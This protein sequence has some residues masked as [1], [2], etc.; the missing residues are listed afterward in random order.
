MNKSYIEIHKE[1]LEPGMKLA[2]DIETKFGAT[3]L[4]KNSI[5][6]ADE[7][8]KLYNLDQKYFKIVNQNQSEQ[9]DNLYKIMNVKVEYQ[10]KI[11]Q[12]KELF[13]CLKNNDTLDKKEV[14]KL[15][16]E[17]IGLANNM[18][19][20]DVL[21][22]VRDTD[23]Y[24][25][26]HLLNVG[27]HANFFAEWLDLSEKEKGELTTAGIL[28]DIGKMKIPNEIL[29]KPGELNDEEYEIIKTHSRES[30]NIVKKADFISEKTRAGILTHH[31]QYNGKGYPL[32]LKGKEI[33]Y[34][35]RIL[36]IIDAFDAITSDKIYNPASSP[37][38][39]MRIFKEDK[40]QF[41]DYELKE[42]F[43]L[44]MPNIFVQEKV[45][46]NDGRVAEIKFINPDQPDKPIISLDGKIINL[47]NYDELY[48]DK[49]V[50]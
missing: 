44:N 14:E 32:G 29:K 34:Y 33:P 10:K 13:N 25:Y 42:I 28:H 46:L 45:R 15:T 22:I 18:E 6:T 35:G 47:K 27:L 12:Y 41:Y 17:T 43:L 5:L 2:Q 24:T 19:V 1:K 16:K 7:I 26:S 40:N 4:S 38:E 37:F 11:K 50:R 39:A 31:E 21:N 36:A 23:E 49:I 20:T 30:Y 8:K 48:I 9:K 3:L